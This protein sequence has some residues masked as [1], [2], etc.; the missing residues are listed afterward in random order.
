MQIETDSYVIDDIQT[1]LTESS[2][3]EIIDYTDIKN[4]QDFLN[5]SQRR[6]VIE[7]EGTC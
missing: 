4:L 5:A 6:N 3:K 1:A 2:K 7:F